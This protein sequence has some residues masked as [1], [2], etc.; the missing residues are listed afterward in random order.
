MRLASLLLLTANVVYA[1]S[2]V[3]TRLVLDD[4]PPATLAFLRV[5]LG[6]AVLVP[7]GR[8]EPQ[9]TAR[10][11]LFW[12]GALGFAAAFALSNWGIRSSSATNAALL[13]IVEPLALLTLGP[14]LLGERLTPREAMGAAA[15][16]AGALVVV[17]DGIPGVTGRVLP[18]WRG[19]LLL[20]LSGLAYASYSL[21]GRTILTAANA[22]AVTARSIVWG[23]VVMAPL[24]A[25]EWAAGARPVP[26]PLAVAGT[27]YLAV[28]ITAGGYLLWNVGLARMEASRAAAFLTVQPVVGALLGALVLGERVTI[29]T[30]I[31]GAL[32]VVGLWMTVTS[33][34]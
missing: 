25:L 24:A 28:V 33:R 22:T 21:L 4:V 11:R 23:T 1:T 3:A 8:R 32:I 5:V 13:I 18:H 16:V 12:M 27:L 20:I 10:G 9:P 30:A 14:V 29:F 7:L 6:A 17:F 2:Y 31:G 15:A 26:T 19:D 34:R